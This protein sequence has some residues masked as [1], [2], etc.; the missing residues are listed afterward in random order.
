MAKVAEF[1]REVRER[2]LDSLYYFTKV[3]LGYKDLVPRFHMPMCEFGEDT[4]SHNMLCV[5]PRGVFKSTILT[6]ARNMWITLPR[7]ADHPL[8]GILGPHLHILITSAVEPNAEKFLA[9]IRKHYE[10][11][12]ILRGAFPD[13][14]PTPDC[15]WNAQ[16]LQLNPIYA[17]IVEGEATFEAKGLNTKLASRHYDI[18]H[19]DDPI[20]KDTVESPRL[21]RTAQ[22]NVA[23][24]ES[25]VR[26][27]SKVNQQVIIGTPYA[28]DDIVTS[29]KE[30]PQYKVFWIGARDKNGECTIPE[31]LDE[32]KLEAKLVS[33]GPYIY[34]CQYACDPAAPE[35]AA[36]HRDALQPIKLRLDGNIRLPSGELVNLST[37]DQGIGVDQATI[38]NTYSKCRTAIILMGMNIDHD[39]FLIDGSVGN[40]DPLE[41]CQRIIELF[42]MYPGLRF[43]DIE[44]EA[45][46][47]T[48]QFWLEKT[49]KDMKKWEVAALVDDPA[50]NP[51]GMGKIRRIYN[52]LLPF[53][54]A[55]KIYCSAHL[56]EVFA[57]WQK[58][59]TDGQ[60]YDALDAVTRVVPKLN[61]NSELLAPGGDQAYDPEEEEDDAFAD[62]EG[63]DRAAH[64]SF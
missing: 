49:A 41:T 32:K 50:P 16:G 52:R 61:P 53:S 19:H 31:L 63:L 35:N 39:L 54:K 33:Q 3:T 21:R 9:I 28:H 8:Y 26:E 25:V 51:K 42:D 24:A 6:V 17:E 13:V 12:P 56:L 18:R 29:C 1:Y 2:S 46:L 14:L 10:S 38:K 22:R 27:T 43:I 20:D 57:E 58:F 44:G 48:L 45:Y 11:N 7:P 34:A 5:A 47:S 59:P 23:Y 30:D 36:F 15:T 55:R 37:L 62:E 40:L 4:Y 60:E 64:F